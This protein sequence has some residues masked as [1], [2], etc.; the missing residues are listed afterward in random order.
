[1]LEIYGVDANL[2]GIQCH[3]KTDIAIL[4]A[5]LNR[6]GISD[7]LFYK[8]L[9]E[10][11]SII[12][13]EVSGNAKRIQ[14]DVCPSIPEILAEIR[15]L[16]KL[17]GVASGNLESVGWHKLSAAGI[18]D[19]FSCGSFGDRSELRLG[20]FENAVALAKSHFGQDVSV[21]FVGDTPDDIEAARHVNARIISVATGI[22][23]AAELARYSPDLCC[24]CCDEL[25]GSLR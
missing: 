15:A 11:L 19:F 8:K 22:F 18:R 13:S 2:D 4:R 7:D 9:P 21:C 5:A 3:G 16:N 6:R 23:T 12:R 25:L 17:L 14:A 1:M 10:A 24:Q 20:V